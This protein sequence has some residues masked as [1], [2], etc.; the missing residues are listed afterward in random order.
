MDRGWR[1]LL[2]QSVGNTDMKKNLHFFNKS[3]S[4]NKASLHQQ[5]G[6]TVIQLSLTFYN[7]DSQAPDSPES[8]RRSYQAE[9]TSIYC[10]G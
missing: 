9:K 4:N 10:K 8:D 3:L 1:T 6:G 7:M 2:P 5:N